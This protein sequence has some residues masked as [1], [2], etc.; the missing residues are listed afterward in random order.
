MTAPQFGSGIG[1]LGGGHMARALL[2]ALRR[3]GVPGGSL[4]VCEAVAGRAA[5]LRQD[6]GVVLHEQAARCIEASE[7]LVLAVKPQDLASALA[8]LTETL[9][10]R[11]PLVIS[12]AAGVPTDRLREW[13]AGAPVIRAMPNR[14]AMVGVG[15]AGLYA[16]P[17][18]PTEL[19]RRAEALLGAAGEV[20][21]IDDE[22]LMDVV[23]AVSGSGPAY[24]FALAEALG[25]AGEA[26]GLAPAVARTLARSTLHGAGALAHAE[27]GVDLATL[28]DSV[29]SK[30]GTTAA[31]LEVLRQGGLDA[32]VQDAVEAAVQRGRELGG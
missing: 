32:L 17:E 5:S 3:Q 31:A 19:R 6:F 20:V 8:P 22:T 7:T 28:R 29:T 14:P 30:G 21:W 27:L 11:R 18:V 26:A 2:G 24:F 13:C 15:A 1:F 16:G 23:T 12:I 4:H 10:S 25:R 9:A